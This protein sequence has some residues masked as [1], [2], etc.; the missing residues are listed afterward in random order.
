MESSKNPTTFGEIYSVICRWKSETTSM[1]I[2]KASIRN[3]AA[4]ADKPADR[5]WRQVSLLPRL[6][7]VLSGRRW[8]SPTQLGTSKCRRRCLLGKGL[9]HKVNI[10]VKQHFH[11][12]Q[13]VTY[14]L[15]WTALFTC[16]RRSRPVH[17]G[18]QRCLLVG[19]FS[20]SLHVG[21]C[22]LCGCGH[23]TF[24]HMLLGKPAKVHQVYI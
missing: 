4:I 24:L 6:G 20:A 2:S 19:H 10:S 14:L 21:R 16:H 13:M 3:G 17:H 12:D 5:G 7:W 18:D 15:L 22:C 1:K 9:L 23:R 11:L 8:R